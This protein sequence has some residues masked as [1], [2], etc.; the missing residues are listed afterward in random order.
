MAIGKGRE[1]TEGNGII[2]KNFLKLELLLRWGNWLFTYSSL[3]YPLRRGFISQGDIKPGNLWLREKGVGMTLCRLRRLGLAGQT[4]EVCEHHP[5][6]VG[7]GQQWTARTLQ[8][9]GRQDEELGEDTCFLLYSCFPSLALGG[10]LCNIRG[11]LRQLLVSC[12]KELGINMD[13]ELLLNFWLRFSKAA[14]SWMRG[15]FISDGKIK[16]VEGRSKNRVYVFR[17]GKR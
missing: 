11:S 6:G 7:A 13:S 12:W 10:K 17:I 4:V 9:V 8:A 3:G 15:R 2:G 5:R 14:N 16:W 1:G